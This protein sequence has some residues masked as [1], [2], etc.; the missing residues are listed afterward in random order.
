MK[1]KRA[2]IFTAL[3]VQT[4][5]VRPAQATPRYIVLDLGTLPG[6]TVSGGYGINSS[7]QVTGYS[8]TT[9][10]QP[11]FPGFFGSHAFLYSGGGMSDLGVLVGADSFG[12]ADSSGSGINNSGQVTGDALI[13]NGSAKHAFLY[14]DGSMNDIHT[15]G[16]PNQDGLQGGP[17]SHGYGINDSGQVAG[18]SSIS[19]YSSA[20]HAFLYSGGGMS[21]L[22]TL[23]GGALSYGYGINNSGQVTGESAVNAGATIYHAF[24]YS[25]GSMRDIGTLGGTSSHAYAINNAGQ[26]TGTSDY[27]G[28]GQHTF[29]YAINTGMMDLGTLGGFTSRGNGINNSGQVVGN[30]YI[31][32]NS[33]VHAFLYSGGAMYDLNNIALTGQMADFSYLQIAQGIN[34]HGLIT[35]YGITTNGATRAFLAIPFQISTLTRLANG[36]VHLQCQGVPNVFNR[37]EVSSN[38]GQNS[39]SNLTSLSADAT[40]AFQYDYVDAATMRF[41]RIAYP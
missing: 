11:G 30:S 10:S 29:L 14:A 6:G 26:V 5:T 4:I 28:I 31:T 35:G 7:G 37:I 16:D 39:F 36:Q 18:Y 21:D 34:D 2:L 9:N 15:L 25:G 13:P 27:L 33:A 8:S 17:G 3:L 41:Y 1:L 32:G 23:P 19:N 12:G 20:S 24:L 22:G 38:L 40:G